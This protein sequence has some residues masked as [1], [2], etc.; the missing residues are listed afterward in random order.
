MPRRFSKPVV[1]AIDQ[2][3]ILGIRPGARSDH[4]VIGIWAVVVNGRVFARSWT[5]TKG[6]WYRTLLDDPLGTLQ[7]GT[8]EI[9]ARAVSVKSERLSD[10]VEDAYAAKYDT[11][12]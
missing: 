2:S 4:R 10:A 8:R 6:G 9:R 3:K 12:G 5:L 7:V 1:A 11:P